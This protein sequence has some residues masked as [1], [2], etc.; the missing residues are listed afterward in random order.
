MKCNYAME[1]IYQAGTGVSAWAEK[2]RDRSNA[3]RLETGKMTL[4]PGQDLV[5]NVWKEWKT[6]MVFD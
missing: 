5:G 6:N 3:I 4:K 1:R 2:Q